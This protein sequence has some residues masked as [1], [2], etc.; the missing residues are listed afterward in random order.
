MENPIFALAEKNQ[1][2]AKNIIEETN[3]IL[4]SLLGVVP[5]MYFLLVLIPLCCC[6]LKKIIF[7]HSVDK[8]QDR[9]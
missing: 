4:N 6:L 9:R 3:I 5:A 1:K 2:R 8:T 7:G